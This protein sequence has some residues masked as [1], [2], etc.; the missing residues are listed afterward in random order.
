MGKGKID[1]LV[2]ERRNSIANALELRPSYTNPSKYESDFEFVKDSPNL[3]IV[4]LE[5]RGGLTWVTVS[6]R[7]LVVW[8]AL[9]C[10]TS[11]LLA[12]TGRETV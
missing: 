5:G 7:H 2:Q 6:Q 8:G 9:F 3:D 4:L 12:D 11:Q 1:G 10:S